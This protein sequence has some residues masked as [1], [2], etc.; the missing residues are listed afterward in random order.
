MTLLFLFFTTSIIFSFLCSIWEAVLLSVTTPYIKRKVQAGDPAGLLLQKYKADID[1]P[2]SA[3]LTLNTIAHT[4]GA[5]GVGAQAGKVFGNNHFQFAGLD[6]GYESIIAAIMTLAI[7][8]LS[9]II[10][11]TIGAN[12]WPQLAPITAK[13]LRILIWVLWPLVWLSQKITR[14]LKKDK[15]RS[16]LS[17][18]DITA[19]THVGEES[20]ALHRKES[21]IIRNLLRLKD[22][23]VRDIMTPRAVMMSLKENLTCGEYYNRY[24]SSSFSRIPIYQEREDNIT[25]IVLRTAI[26]AEV[27]AD[28]HGTLLAEIKIPAQYINDSGALPQLLEKLTKDRAHLA[29]VVD[30]FGSIA[31]LVTMED[32]METLLGIEIL[33][34]TDTVEDLQKLARSQWQKRAKSLGIIE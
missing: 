15:S 16:I 9:E 17:R 14:G 1:R 18:A 25:G 3:I 22:L 4:V 13:S 19:M 29:M 20:G 11:K 27:A 2:L 8:I 23:T 26:L 6:L 7:L 10:P 32:L 33:D 28:R 21:S 5:I 12:M 31:G 24:Q 30:D 34:E